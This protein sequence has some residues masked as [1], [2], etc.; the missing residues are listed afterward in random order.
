MFGDR[1]EALV[2]DW[3]IARI[4]SGRAG[5]SIDRS[6]SHQTR[7]GQVLGTVGYMSPEQTLGA[8]DALGPE[9]DVWSLGVILYETLTV[10]RAYKGGFDEVAARVRRGPLRVHEAELG[11]VPAPLKAIIERSTQV[12]PGERYRDAA[13][14]AAAVDAY[15]ERRMGGDA[16]E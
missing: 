15:L 5:A 9:S 14:L 13:A 4:T 1:G 16:T 6:V 10:R 8:H 3:G 11:D 12:A 7:P 2:M